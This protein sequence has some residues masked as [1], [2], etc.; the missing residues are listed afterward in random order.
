MGVP[1][2]N[3]SHPIFSITQSG[4]LVALNI[5][6]LDQWIAGPRPPLLIR[7][8]DDLLTTREQ[9]IE[10]FQPHREQILTAAE[11][12]LR[13][14][15]QGWGDISIQHGSVVNFNA[16]YG[17]S[18]KYGFHYWFWARPLLQAFLLTSDQRYLDELAALFDAWYDQLPGIRGEIENLDVIFYELG[19]GLRTQI[20]LEF[21][22]LSPYQPAHL[23]KTLL[24]SARWLYQHEL[25]GYRPGNWQVMGS[26][27]LAWIAALIPE[28][29]ESQAWMNV[30]IAR[31][32]EHVDRDLYADGCHWERVPSDYMLTVY[33]DLRN[34]ALLSGRADLQ[35]G[36]D[37]MLE[38][39][40]K[41]LPGDGIIPAIN[42]GRRIPFPVSILQ[43]LSHTAQLNSL[44][45]LSPSPCTQEEGKGGGSSSAFSVQRSVFGS[46]SSIHFPASGFTI[47]RDNRFYVLINHG[48]IAGGHTHHDA[49]SFELHIDHLP[50][51][52][53]SG[54]GPSYDDPQYE[55]WYTTP[56]AHN[57]LEVAGAKLDRPSAQG[58]D[59]IFAPSPYVDYFAA[60]HQGY[61]QSAGITHR[62]HFLLFHNQFLLLIEEINASK[63]TELIWH[64]HNPSP[65]S[66]LLGEPDWI[67]STSSA[68]ASTANIPNYSNYASIP[69]QQFR[70][71]VLPGHHRFAF[72]L[73]HE[74]NSSLT[75]H[76]GDQWTITAGPTTH[77]ILLSNPS[78]PS[79]AENDY[80][81]GQC[82][83]WQTT[84][85][86][87]KHWSVVS[88]TFFCLNNKIL[89][90]T[91]SSR[92]A[93]L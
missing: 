78:D 73:T 65:L 28:F 2:D 49:L 87:V 13:H 26:A 25:T 23:L 50:I 30:A 72:L 4:L 88:S 69:W 42:D 64:L 45:N 90:Q 24:A 9:A 5:Q 16:N 40:V 33:K 77:H 67:S 59:C 76:S 36:A 41:M 10:S 71:H 93:H 34:V 32:L 44:G 82:A 61:F 68:M 70:R 80:F 84:N 83:I 79:E 11:R 60:A 46:N 51:A 89:H 56:A 62:R 31:L 55:S 15:I 6:S 8:F 85:N 53:D 92:H 54:I 12:I 48:P 27:G 17:R 91:N 39:Y 21:L 86:E 43:H 29:K 37:R 74:S 18:G 47:L 22:Q 58:Q 3:S 20:F 66:V 35:A 81:H 38:W 19:L 63:P 52:I 1:E 75:R 7:D 57:M 14:D